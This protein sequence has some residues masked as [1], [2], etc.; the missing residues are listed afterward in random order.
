MTNGNG[1]G[2]NDLD[3]EGA[4]TLGQQGKAAASP[5]APFRAGGIGSRDWSLVRCRAQS[6]L[7]EHWEQS[8]LCEG[9]ALS[10]LQGQV[11][12]FEEMV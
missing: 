12:H 2:L 3:G 6:R 1:S 9:K 8:D 4:D 7:G 5:L 10:P 11:C